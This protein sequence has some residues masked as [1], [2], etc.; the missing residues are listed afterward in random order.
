MQVSIHSHARRIFQILFI[1]SFKKKITY[2]IRFQWL[3]VIKCTFSQS[4]NRF[5]SANVNLLVD[6]IIKSYSINSHHLVIKIRFYLLIINESYR[7]FEWNQLY[8]HAGGWFVKTKLATCQSFFL[9][10]RKTI[11]ENKH[12][13]RYAIVQL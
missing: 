5:D 2:G 9:D 3:A 6:N 13:E 8:S 4:D 11:Y 12:S 7:D 1:L 10:N